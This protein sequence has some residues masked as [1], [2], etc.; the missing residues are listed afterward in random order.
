[1]QS[2]LWRFVNYVSCL[3]T[4][5]FYFLLHYMFSSIKCNTT[6]D[7]RYFI[8]DDEER[9]EDEKKK[10]QRDIRAEEKNKKI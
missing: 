2:T 6:E 1:M 7:L 3:V 10:V 8:G 5:F 4:S 9:K